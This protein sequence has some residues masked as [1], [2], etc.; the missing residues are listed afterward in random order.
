[1]NMKP[2]V[3]KLIPASM[4]KYLINIRNHI[5]LIKITTNDYLRFKKFSFKADNPQTVDQ[6][7][8]LIT[9]SYHSIEKGLSYKEIR[10]G[11]GRE[12]VFNLLNLIKKYNE[13]GYDP[14]LPS[15]LTAIS[16]LNKYIEFHQANAFSVDEIKEKFKNICKDM[17]IN[18][19]IGGFIELTQS[20]IL[21]KTNS[22]FR[23][24]AFSRFSVRDFSNK[25]VD[26]NLIE[27][28]IDIAKK[29]PSACNRQAWHV[30]VVRDNEVKAEILKNHNGSKGFGENIDTLLLITCNLSSFAFPREKNQVYIDGG[31]YS[32]SLLY[33]LHYK[34]LATC[35]LS[36]SLTTTQENN[37]RRILNVEENHQLI[38]FIAVGNYI[39]K[40]KVP[41]SNRYESNMYYKTY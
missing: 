9:K 4:L 15:V 7:S 3:K 27:K 41:M 8:A 17:K 29:T 37:V 1:M 24:F 16:V 18:Y 32:M 19:D 22:D 13:R 31:L 14:T 36:A 12:I 6:F 35:S 25:R 5:E 26:I 40:F 28:A 23:T 11:F 10:L 33:A 20:D 30:K 38:L 34:G 21:E 39:D 2:L